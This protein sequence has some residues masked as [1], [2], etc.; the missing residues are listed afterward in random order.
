MENIPHTNGSPSP[1]D[2]KLIVS[3]KAARVAE[4]D[5]TVSR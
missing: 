3:L 1:V 2:L 5:Y 4:M